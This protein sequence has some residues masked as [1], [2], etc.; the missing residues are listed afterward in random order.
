MGPT[1]G[2]LVVVPCGRGKVWD[3]E[4]GRGPTA[5]RDAYTGAPFRVNRAYAE[6]FAERWVIL[7]AK[8]GL[9]DPDFL[10]P[11]SYDVTFKEPSTDPITPA[12]VRAQVG[13]QGL[14]R[15]RTVIGLGGKEYRAIVQAAFGHA[16]TV[17]RFPFTGLSIGKAMQAIKAAIQAGEPVQWR[18][19][20]LKGEGPASSVAQ[21]SSQRKGVVD[22]RRAPTAVEFRHELEA[23]L[24]E[25]RHQ[26]RVALEVT[27]RDLHRRVGGYFG[28]NH[29][30]PTCC[31]VMWTRMGPRDT[32]LCQP[33][34]GRG[35]KLTIRYELG[36]S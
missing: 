30:M 25:A 22:G 27:S 17:V 35:A 16:S 29:R 9:I 14:D 15:F 24:D 11:G 19:N 31:E 7:S 20:A 6:R 10:L 33:P 5:A 8:Y 36:S 32:V 1:D 18:G 3:T 23:M 4:P 34:S 12:A 21:P 13:T 26:G 28:N 2:V